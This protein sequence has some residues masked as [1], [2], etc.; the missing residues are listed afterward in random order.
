MS[1][2]SVPAIESAAGPATDIHAQ[3]NKRG[4]GPVSDTL[5]DALRANRGDIE[6]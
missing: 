4:V 6:R 5:M 3:A 1:R 2:I